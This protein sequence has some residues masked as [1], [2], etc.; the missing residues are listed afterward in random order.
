M[1][2]LRDRLYRA[3]GYPTGGNITAPA[4]THQDR[5]RRTSTPNVYNQPQVSSE[6]L[7]LSL[8]MLSKIYLLEILMHHENFVR[9]MDCFV[10]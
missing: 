10:Y 2:A 6:S 5:M 8:N 9:L 3:L 4:I 1:V 7:F